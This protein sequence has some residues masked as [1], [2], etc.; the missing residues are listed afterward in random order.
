MDDAS[1][2]SHNIISDVTARSQEVEAVQMKLYLDGVRG[3]VLV[4]K[5]PTSWLSRSRF[6]YILWQKMCFD[7]VNRCQKSSVRVKPYTIVQSAIRSTC[8]WYLVHGRL[9]ATIFI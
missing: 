2:T 8:N 9:V 1:T 7:S 5:A 6:H 4:V 3:D